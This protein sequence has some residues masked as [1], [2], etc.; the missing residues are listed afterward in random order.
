MEEACLIRRVFTNLNTVTDL[1]KP[2][3]IYLDNTNLLYALCL[4]RPEIG[5]LRETFLANQIASA[6]HVVEYAGYKKG[7]YR[8]DGN[9]IIEVGGH[10]KGFKQIAN[11]PNAYVAADEIESAIPGKIPLWAFGFLY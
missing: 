5:T 8:I 9:V 1:Q 11:Q 3:K 4:E 7:D 6:G 2:D 10:E